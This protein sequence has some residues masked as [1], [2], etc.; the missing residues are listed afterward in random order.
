MKSRLPL[1]IIPYEI[2]VREIDGCV[3][4]AYEYAKQGGVSL[5]GQKQA[6]FPIIKF[7]RNSIW[8][9]KSIVPGEVFIQKM[10]YKNKSKVFSYDV[11]GLAPS[12]GEIG[13][14]AR[15]SADS[16]KLT[17][18]HFC[19]NK[20]ELN[21]YIKIFP[22]FEKKFICSGIPIQES[23]F[24]YSKL[25]NKKNTA[26][27][28]S[29]F[30]LIGELQEIYNQE[31][32]YN[33]SGNNLKKMAQLK[34]EICMQKSG[35]KYTEDFIDFLLEKGIKV[36]IRKHPAELGNIW[37]KYRNNPQVTFD[38]FTKPITDS[39]LNSDFLILFNSTV[40]VQAYYMGK[41]SFLYFPKEEINKYQSTFSK[42]A[43]KYSNT[44]NSLSEFEKPK[45]S[46]I[47]NKIIMKNKKISKTILSYM[48]SSFKEGN[49]YYNRF[50]LII[51]SPFFR[52]KRL[53]IFLL[54]QQKLYQKIFPN[55]VFSPLYYKVGKNK[56]PLN[57]YDSVK[58]SINNM[59][60][61]S[62]KIK[63]KKI[64]HNLIEFSLI[65]S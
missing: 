12:E 13:V 55:N 61:K 58:R 52:L 1:L 44:L 32:T 33:V 34:E 3:L 30:P 41:K 5:I 28:V 37:E 57:T 10:I 19:W 18:Y 36:N 6:L 51:I 60:L 9:L 20:E 53:I 50:L 56:S 22:N 23:W 63:L 40:S 38:D 7:L 65:K 35:K 43:M 2:L 17:E 39:I 14:L 16:L 29:G 11:E 48:L 21:R 26:L 8:F 62:K 47:D 25:S 64:T 27:F 15:F 54:S 24:K 59:K 45:K 49:Y 42:I 4:L 31:Q 46:L